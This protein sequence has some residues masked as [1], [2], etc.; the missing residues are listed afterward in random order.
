M[1]LV[2]SWQD[3]VQVQPELGRSGKPCEIAAVRRDVLVVSK[4]CDG[5]GARLILVGS[6][7]CR[8]HGNTRR[9]SPRS[10]R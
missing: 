1:S 6:D 8:H 4:L 3:G 7:A 10:I 9:K 5:G 2:G